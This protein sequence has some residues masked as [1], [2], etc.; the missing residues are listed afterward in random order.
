[1]GEKCLTGFPVEKREGKVIEK[2]IFPEETR[3]GW[4]IEKGINYMAISLIVIVATRLLILPV[5]HLVHF[6]TVVSFVRLSICLSL[7]LSVYL[8]VIFLLVYRSARF[9]VGLA[10]NDIKLGKNS[11][12][13]FLCLIF[14]LF[15]FQPSCLS[16]RHLLDV[17]AVGPM[18]LSLPFYLR[19]FPI[20]SPALILHLI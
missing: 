1:M 3:E 14:S 11:N 12:N 17:T 16:L 20:P 4:V 6:H 19:R 8:P 13:H 9:I 7:C 15:F 5:F 2:D 10:P 18:K